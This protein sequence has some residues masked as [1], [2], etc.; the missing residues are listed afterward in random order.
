MKR[1][2]S[3]EQIYDKL[4]NKESFSELECEYLA[5][6]E[7]L[8]SRGDSDHPKG[9]DP[10]VGAVVRGED[11]HI[12]AYAHRANAFEGDHAEYSILKGLL[13][14][15]DLSKCDFFT[16]LE[17]CVDA[18]RG[19]IGSSCTSLLC[20]S[21][22]NRIHIGILDSSNS[23]VFGK[24]IEELFRSGKILIP[25]SENTR[26]MIEK[27][28]PGF[29]KSSTKRKA[30]IER[31]KD[32]IFTKF[33][34]G[35]LEQYLE[36]KYWFDANQ[37]EGKDKKAARFDLDAEKN[38]F[39]S[40]LL[41]RE[42]VSFAAN[43][44]DIDQQLKIM[45]FRAE[46]LKT[47]SRKVK[48]KWSD[49]NESKDE[50]LPDAL[51]LVYKRLMEIYANEFALSNFDKTEYKEAIVNALVHSDY[52]ENATLIYLEKKKGLLS[53]T[54]KAADSI[55]L[56]NLEKLKDYNASTFPGNGTIVDLF[57][58]AGYCERDAKGQSTFRKANP[59]PT[60]EIKGRIVILKMKMI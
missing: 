48:I 54:N 2:I 13:N 21:A 35:A 16:T 52:G 55:P 5:Y 12:I 34:P 44:V 60:Y 9:S 51:P 17:P 59:K 32:E 28:W 36:D 18:V 29:S 25:F 45:F 33:Q 40:L 47:S 4:N 14:G 20:S 49:G 24:G 56:E 15:G 41:E 31:V 10:L 8:K 3:E 58:M 30:E 1:K 27:S 23:K 43:K 11:G 22:I 39:A 57:N 26:S 53:I 19:Q 42:F 50:V 37:K 6:Y 46:S 38:K 7:S